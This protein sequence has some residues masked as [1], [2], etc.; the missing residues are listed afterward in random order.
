MVTVDYSDA[1]YDDG[2]TG[3]NRELVFKTLFVDDEV[4]FNAS[5]HEELN[6]LESE[7]DL[8]ETVRVSEVR[9]VEVDDSK[10]D[11]MVRCPD[12]TV[13]TQTTRGR[14]PVLVLNDTEYN[15]YRVGIEAN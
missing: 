9:V 8:P 13:G 7:V 14:H 2:G 4:G 10:V 15:H 6:A 3:L 11:F 5:V 1:S 12:L